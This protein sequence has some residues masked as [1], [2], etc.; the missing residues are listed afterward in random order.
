VKSN[1]GKGG[2]LLIGGEKREK[3]EKRGKEGVKGLYFR[4]GKG[5][6]LKAQ[7]NSAVRIPQC[8]GH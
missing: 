2:L 7:W 1:L 3:R 5:G 8:D 4:G 6:Y